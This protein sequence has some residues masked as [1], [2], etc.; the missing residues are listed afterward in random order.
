MGMKRFIPEQWIWPKR[1][2]RGMRSYPVIWELF[3]KPWHKDPY[4]TTSFME[5]TLSKTNIAPKN[6]PSPKGKYIVL[7]SNHPFSGAQML[8]SWISYPGPRFFWEGRLRWVWP[9]PHL[10]AYWEPWL[11]HEPGVLSTCTWR[12][13][14]GLGPVVIGSPPHFVQP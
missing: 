10:V 6:R 11:S 14:P 12:N 5:S 7:Y 1:L 2:F 13:I 9:A 3:H 8:V 4:Q